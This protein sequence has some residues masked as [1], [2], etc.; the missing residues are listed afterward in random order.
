MTIIKNQTGNY[1]ILKQLIDNSTA[2]IDDDAMANKEFTLEDGTVLKDEDL[3]AG[4]GSLLF[5]F[6]E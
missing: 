5:N 6:K 4:L 3:I 1:A 2:V